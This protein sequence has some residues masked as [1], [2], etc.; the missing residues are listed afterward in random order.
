MRKE[1]QI[2]IYS[3]SN[4]YKHTINPKIVM[5][6][7]SF[8]SNMNGGQWSLNIQLNELIT[9]T[10]EIEWD[11]IK[12][13][14]FDENNTNGRQIYYWFVNKIQK[15]QDIN[16]QTVTLEC[17]GIIWL[18]NKIIF[19]SG[20]F[21]PTL[22]QDPAVT[23]KAVIDYFNTQY[24]G[25]LIGYG[26]LHVDTYGT[27]INMSFDYNTC[28]E[29]ITKI[30]EATN[31]WRYIDSSWQMRFKPNPTTSTHT[32]TNQKNVDNIDVQESFNDMVNQLYLWRNWG[33][34]K[35]YSDATSK[36]TYWIKEKRE[37]KTDLIDETSQD[38]YGNNFIQD[39]KD[40]KKETSVTVN[41]KYD[42]ETIKPGDALKILN[43][44]YS[45]TN[46]QILRVQYSTNNVVLS[47]DKA[48]SLVKTIQSI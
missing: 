35:T 11:I 27:N 25:S 31:F 40:P 2:K 18:L 15:L 3:K 9:D 41:N 33:V 37:S 28:M 19:Y 14:V 16:S 22:N 39:N 21:T 6:N 48:T 12:I 34:Y 42:I 17:I 45:I 43:L 7:I 1:F 10:A 20:S 13:S 8:Q 5:S 30:T 38:E 23:I 29:V 4:V 46:I 47:L 44:E 32:L 26:W 36:T 24:A